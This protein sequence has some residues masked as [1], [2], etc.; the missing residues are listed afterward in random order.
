[1]K[2]TIHRFIV[3][4]QGTLLILLFSTTLGWSQQDPL[5]A[6]YLN[7]PL[8]INPAHAG[9]NNNLT[10]FAG[11]RNQW[12]GFDG[13]PTTL[14][15]GGHISLFQNKMAAGLVIVSDRLGENTNT[16]VTAS[17]AYKIRL[18]AGTT[19]AF[20]MQAGFLNYKVDPSLLNL[21]DLT[22][23]V[24]T[25][26][27]QMT[28]SLGAGVMVKSDKFL[29]GI[30]VPRMLNGTLDLGG[31]PIKVYQQHYYIMGSYLF[32]LSER[33]LFKPTTLLKA[34][35]GSPLSTD[36]NLN[37]IIDRKYVAG[38]YTRN[39]SAFGVL[40]Q[41]TFLDKYKLAYAL[42][43]PT[44]KSVGTRFVTNEIM[45]SMRLSALSFHDAADSGF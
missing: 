3:L 28:P 2:H 39:F 8:L 27:N 44:N 18:N 31:Q 11:Y 12:A 45:L 34:V 14:N 9:I 43:V 19:L 16:Q 1:M 25:P 23:P 41:V 6:L 35:Q 37:L 5:Y 29:V 38:V 36:L 20:G 10:V 4:S 26:L 40:A 13:N 17:Y 33:I 30:S 32:F 21:Q 42:E 24:F 15:A 7:N 22:D